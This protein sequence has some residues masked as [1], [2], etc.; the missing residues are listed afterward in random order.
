MKRFLTLSASLLIVLAGCG[1]SGANAIE[2]GNAKTEEVGSVETSTFIELILGMGEEREM[3][4]VEKYA[5]EQAARYEAE[6]ARQEMLDANAEK[7]ALMVKK[8][9]KYVGKTYYVFSG[10]SPAGWDCSG[11]VSWGYAQIG[12]DLYHG[13]STQKHSGKI[14]KT[15]K[16]G[17][18]V[19]FGWK[20]YRGSQHSGIY[21]GDGQM[22][23]AGGYAGMRT[24]ITDI[25]D[26]AKGSGNTLVT[27]TRILA[28]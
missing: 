12:K 10:A 2:T 16:V 8:L 5:A 1:A 18:I 22:L 19:S 25:S 3:G 7:L 14:V 9:K 4:L 20:G 26:W 17:D 6:L 11:L 15:P 27:Y 23:H 13:A 28:N 24:E 21:L